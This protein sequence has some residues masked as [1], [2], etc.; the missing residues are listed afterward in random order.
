MFFFL[1]EKKIK[2]PEKKAENNPKVDRERL[3]FPREDFRKFTP[4][5]PKIVP[6]KKNEKLCPR[7]PKSA[8]EKYG[9][10]FFCAGIF[11]IKYTL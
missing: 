8:R 11:C 1:P 7:K 3:F 4:E 10:N 5:K 2:L 9:A 6:E